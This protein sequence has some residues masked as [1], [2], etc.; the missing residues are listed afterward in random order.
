MAVI[1]NLAAN[2]ETIRV[3]NAAAA[4]QTDVEGAS[5]DLA[6][7]IGVRF[8]AALGDVTV[9]SALEFRAEFRDDPSDPWVPVEG[10]ITHTATATDA[11]NKLLILD[12]VRPEK[13]FVRCV[14]ERGS[15]N[16]AVDGIIADV[17]GPK[18]TPVEQG[19]TVLALATIP[20][21]AAA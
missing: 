1:N 20:N 13:R 8:I 2:V 7:K 14:L 21:A 3:A 6:G 9:S 5:I 18:Y 16:A 15:A 10:E 17:Y 12:V 19:A 11:D 4:A